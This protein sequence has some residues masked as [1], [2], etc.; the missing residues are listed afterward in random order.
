M[1][2]IIGSTKSSRI[3]DMAKASDIA[4]SS[5]EWYEIYQAAGNELP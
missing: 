3:E 1:Q 2:V 4:M 5:K